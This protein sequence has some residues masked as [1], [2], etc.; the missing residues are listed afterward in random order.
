MLTLSPRSGRHFSQNAPPNK[1]VQLNGKPK[2]NGQST[3]SNV[4]RQQN[5]Q[6]FTSNVPGQQNGQ[7]FASNV[8]RQQNTIQARAWPQRALPPS[9]SLKPKPAKVN[10]LATPLR[11][12]YPQIAPA[13]PAAA[14]VGVPVPDV[15]VVDPTAPLPF[16]LENVLF[17]VTLRFVSRDINPSLAALVLLSAANRPQMGFFTVVMFNRKF[18]QWAISAW[19]DYTTG[20]GNLIGVGFQDANHAYQRYELHFETNGEMMEFMSTVRSLQAGHHAVQV[21][22]APTLAAPST[23]RPAPLSTPRPAPPTAPSRAPPPL[24]VKPP[25]GFSSV[26][27][28]PGFSS[29]RPPPGFS[30]HVV[31][32]PAP[33][34]TPRP[35]PHSTSRPA[36]PSTSRPAPPSTPFSDLLST[37][38]PAPNTTSPRPTPSLF[39]KT[40]PGFPS[41]KP[42]PGFSSV[43]PPPG[44]E[45][46]VVDSPAPL[47][48]PRPAPNTTSPR[49]TPSV[50]VKPPPGFPSAKPPPG[51]S[52]LKPPP[53]FQAHV[54]DS[55]FSAVRAQVRSP[56]TQESR[57]GNSPRQVASIPASNQAPV[58]RENASSV[59]K[60]S[61][62][63]ATV[64]QDTHLSTETINGSSQEDTPASPTSELEQDT[65]IAFDGDDI[66]VVSQ[67]RS[68]ATELLSTLDPL[69]YSNDAGAH[70]PSARVSSA[71]IIDTARHLF[72]FF[73]LSG[74]G[75]R[76]ETIAEL[77]QMAEGVRSGVLE[78]I[79]RDARARGRDAQEI[80]EIRNTV[81]SIFA[82]LTEANRRA[83]QARTKP[84]RI[85][86]T[87]EELLSMR[88]A[89]VQPPDSLAENP[90]LPKRGARSR[91]VSTSSASGFRPRSTP[92]DA[93]GGRPPTVDPSHVSK[94]A[95]AMQWVLWKAPQTQ[96]EPE[97]PASAMQWVLWKAPQTQPEPE[98]PEI[99]PEQVANPEP[100]KA[101][102]SESGTARPATPSATSVASIQ[103]TGLQSSRWASDMTERKH[104]NYFT[105]PAYEKTWSKRSYLEDLAQLDPQAKV[106]AGAEDIVDFYFPMSSNNEAPAGSAAPQSSSANDDR[107]LSPTGADSAAAAPQ[108]TDNI[109]ILR[110]GM[111][112]LSIWSP[113]A[114]PSR[115]SR[116]AARD[117]LPSS[118]VQASRELQGE[119][120]YSVARAERP[121]ATSSLAR[122]VSSR[123]IQ[124]HTIRVDEPRL[125][126]LLSALTTRSAASPEA[127]TGV[128]SV[129]SP[130]ATQSQSPS[131]VSAQPDAP[132]TPQ[133]R[134]R[135]LAAS[136]HSSGAGLS[137][138]GKFHHHLGSK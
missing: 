127:A 9:A 124:R 102:N 77:N 18:C 33:P 57:A 138:S 125:A 14:P 65:L 44:F 121:L 4:T 93:I 137:S 98:M 36:P 90:Y 12:V 34:S 130:P 79:M 71:E 129:E 88:H 132:P 75:G 134:L 59:I 96:A 30:A 66:S 35:T 7:S 100:E 52:S 47:S 24:S 39:G 29:V 13:R 8:T 84:R 116:F 99:E 1:R 128:S 51:F 113:T 117:Q 95:S 17:R 28:P 91:Q 106:T 23:P 61:A 5:G 16:E 54:V 3:A 120:F 26:K 38:R 109:E 49:P 67:P 118:V 20:P 92:W 136:R 63:P 89:A 27:P 133:P 76:T 111:S 104:A 73:F 19:R 2:Q 78:H 69:E 21:E 81:D 37:P 83:V 97:K 11:I 123:R 70:A 101:P 40:P 10:P 82:T 58:V 32:S 53:G 64:A 55:P 126:S 22:S 72:S 122:D 103:D 110:A 68:E 45:A 56:G 114:A 86:Y 94:S 119:Q 62:A 108:M 74:A 43:K 42:P 25:P 60:G 107:V 85:Q 105:G 87:P 80:Q 46:H 31:D 41:V 48:T 50:S 135:G 112:R 15:V 6:S 115:D 131:A